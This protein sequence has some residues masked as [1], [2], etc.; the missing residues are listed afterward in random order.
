MHNHDFDKFLKMTT[1]IFL[2]LSLDIEQRRSIVIGDDDQYLSLRDPNRTIEHEISAGSDRRIRLYGEWNRPLANRIQSRFRFQ[3]IEIF[4][5]NQNA[6]YKGNPN[7]NSKNAHVCK[8]CKVSTPNR[9]SREKKLKSQP[10]KK[11]SWYQNELSQ[12]ATTT[13]ILIRI[14]L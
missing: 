2:I 4:L 10:A 5:I 14:I 12:T 6:K 11:P 9:Y 7:L 13:A 8:K 3:V 1:A